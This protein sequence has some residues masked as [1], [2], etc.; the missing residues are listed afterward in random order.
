MRIWAILVMLLVVGLGG[1]LMAAAA[2][3]SSSYSPEEVARLVDGYKGQ[4]EIFWKIG[5]PM[6]TAL[7]T[8]IAFLVRAI[9]QGHGV[10]VTEVKTAADERRKDAIQRDEIHAQQS[11][12][13]RELTTA[14]RDLQF[15]LPCMQSKPDTAGPV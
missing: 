7:A 15:R 3:A 4:I 8:A 9:L 1:M 12:A 5:T 14:I 10:L 11:E 6:V 2:I 13:F